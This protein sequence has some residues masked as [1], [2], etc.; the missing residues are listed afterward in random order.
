MLSRLFACVLL[1]ACIS[2]A[3]AQDD[4][5]EVVARVDGAEVT[6]DEVATAIM[7]L[8]AEYQQVPME[9]LF[10]PIL[11]QVIDRKLLAEAAKDA[12]MEDSDEYKQQIMLMRE[13]LLQQ[14][15]LQ[16]AVDEGLTEE[17]LDEAYQQYLG[18]FEAQGAGEEIHARHI[19]VNTKEEAEAL[20]ERLDDGEDFAAL[21]QEA[22]IG[23]SGPDG[24]DLGFFKK[25]DMVPEF[26][27]AAFALEPGEISGPVESP[28][29]WH[30]ILVEERRDAEPPQLADVAN[31]LSNQIAQDIIGEEIENLRADADIEILLPEPAPEAAMDGEADTDADADSEN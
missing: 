28:F 21:A 18:D 8:P 25:E 2:P 13:E 4:P 1:I 26:A 16:S 27:D 14:M 10:E 12:G 30:V 15:Y 29:G 7:Q 6:R 5:N 31:Q 20:I 22:S 24:G 19:L 23:P 9:I 11:Q 3:F 17:A